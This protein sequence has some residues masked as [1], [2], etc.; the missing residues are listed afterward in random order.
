MTP[1]LRLVP[2]P[3][4]AVLL[5]TAC[6]GGSDAVGSDAVGSAPSAPPPASASASAS[7]PVP[8]PTSPGPNPGSGSPD[9][10]PSA[11]RSVAVYYVGDTG[12]LGAR[13]YREFHS[14][15]VRNDVIRQAVDAMLSLK[16]TD[17]DYS[18]L[19]PTGTQLLGVSMSGDTATVDLSR[20]VLGANAGAAFEAASVQQLVH[21]VTAAAPSVRG[22][23]ILVEGRS[24]GTVDG[25]EIADL[26]GHGG[27]RGQPFVRAPHAEI[28]GPVW[29]FEPTEGATVERSFDIT[30]EAT[31]FEGTVSWELRRGAAVIARGFATASTGAPGRGKWTARVPAPA[32]G[33]YE[34]RA[35]ESSAEDGAALAVDSKRV[36][37]R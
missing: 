14:L 30:G 31:V 10:S 35:F 7:A 33:D 20:D 11:T 5:L 19:W 21:T 3:A 17:P 9:G 22:V 36:T 25:R 15:P 28:L 27:L 2:A 37:V 23:R 1:T 4:L 6:G 8:V 24:S 18:S 12:R 32:A 29:V 16:S 34:L 13:L 26:W